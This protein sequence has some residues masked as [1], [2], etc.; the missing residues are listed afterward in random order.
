MF[1]E[2]TGF[3][4][5]DSNPNLG[6]PSVPDLA[7][8]AVFL[9]FDGV[10]V[11]LAETPDAIKVPADLAQILNRLGD[12]LG[13]ALAIV[14]GRSV[15]VIEGFLP[16]FRGTIVGS[17]GAERRIDAECDSHP[18]AGSQEVSVIQ[19]VV[20]SFATLDPAFLAE[21][22]PCGAVLHFRRNPDLFAEAHQ[23]MESLVSHFPDFRIQPAKMAFEVKPGDVS[24]ASAIRRLLDQA[25]FRGRT[26]V[27]FGDDATD[28]P[29]MEF[30]LAKGGIAIKVGEGGTRA[31]HRIDT[32][33]EVRAILTEW[34]G[35]Q[36]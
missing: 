15:A 27:Y 14:T 32:P 12:A 34:A 3:A 30:C 18:K 10:L 17:H 33:G 11:D 26:P 9:D 21:N 13:G 1:Y 36:S 7:R 4:P 35:G 25:P 19:G 22:K 16:D 29:A 31:G 5:S 28:E 20:R 2:M 8:T 23:F 24:K 6:A